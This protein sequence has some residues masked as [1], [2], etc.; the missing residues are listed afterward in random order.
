MIQ[1]YIHAV[2]AGHRPIQHHICLKP[3]DNICAT[4]CKC[5]LN[6]RRV[7][8]PFEPQEMGAIIVG[9]F[10]DRINNPGR[11][12]GLWRKILNEYS[13]FFHKKRVPED[14]RTK[15][16]DWQKNC[17]PQDV[18]VQKFMCDYQ[19]WI[20][21]KLARRLVLQAHIRPRKGKR[22]GSG[23]WMATSGQGN[24][25]DRTGLQRTHVSFRSN[26]DKSPGREQSLIDHRIQTAYSDPL[27]A[28][29]NSTVSKV[30]KPKI[31]TPGG[32]VDRK[33]QDIGDVELFCNKGGHD[34]PFGTRRRACARLPENLETRDMQCGSSP[35]QHG[36]ATML[37]GPQIELS[38]VRHFEGGPQST[39]GTRRRA[40]NSARRKEPSEGCCIG[41]GSGER[42]GTRRRV[43]DPSANRTT[44]HLGDFGSVRSKVRGTR[45]RSV[46]GAPG[47][48]RLCRNECA[49]AE[50]HPN[51]KLEQDSAYCC[52]GFQ[53]SG[54]QSTL[55]T[56]RR[57]R[58]PARQKEPSE[59]CC[60]GGGPVER[61]GTRRRV[62]A[63][64]GNRT[65]QHLGDFGSVRS[66]VRCTRRRSVSGAPGPPRLCR[67]E[68]A[69]AGWHPNPK[70]GQDSA[71]CCTGFQIGEGHD[72]S[73]NQ[74][75]CPSDPLS[76][77]ESMSA[78]DDDTLERKAPVRPMDMSLP[79]ADISQLLFSRSPV[80]TIPTYYTSIGKYVFS[81]FQTLTEVTIPTSVSAIGK[82][83]F[84]ECGSLSMVIIPTSVSTIGQ[85]AFSGCTSLRV[86]SIPTSV[87]TI[88]AG[89]FSGCTSLTEV[90]IPMSVTSIGR[91]A[92]MDCESLSVVTIPTSV[93]TVG[94]CAFKGCTALQA[95]TIP[96]SIVKIEACLFFDCR[97]LESV[98]IPMSVTAILGCAFTRCESLSVVTIPTSV[99]T[100]GVK[101]FGDC[102]SLVSLKSAVPPELLLALLILPQCEVPQDLRHCIVSYIWQQEWT[103]GPNTTVH[104]QAFEGC[105]GLKCQRF[106]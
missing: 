40:R 29:K 7:K 20:L 84:M 8:V 82:R 42:F 41:G 62:R 6:E 98:S 32:Q 103:P 106:L 94:D 95:V 104:L 1:W 38:E 12:N 81:G 85:G 69:Q 55:G 2:P 28:G 91:I 97:G 44:Q 63:P 66:K 48:P 53:I 10:N 73:C 68:C 64:S 61:F 26:K 36:N 33:P 46:P 74:E 102:T 100:I 47:A 23:S 56:R 71:Y 34:G 83:A 22:F 80:L 9:Y 75:N 67:N 76:E 11:V 93:N 37:S 15:H 45:R 88:D 86:V 50:R 52:T 21:T 78:K 60:I 30:L 4:N 70:L 101:A 90:S 99:S 3:P 27:A 59:G 96:A 18:P 24:G 89:A 35:Q 25:L 72:S 58:N 19:E 92:F 17:M 31:L 57:A 77:H 105:S 5:T 79:S 87:T 54:P 65:T 49:Q 13:T 51:P 14:L 43:R 39:L 16:R